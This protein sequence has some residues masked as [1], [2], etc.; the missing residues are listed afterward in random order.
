[1]SSR[2]MKT[3]RRIVKDA[4]RK[5]AME[6]RYKQAMDSLMKAKDPKSDKIRELMHEG[7]PQE[8]AIAIAYSEERAGK[9]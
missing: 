5:E 6:Q 9:I 3:L 7:Y 8:Q 1:M 4:I 2:I